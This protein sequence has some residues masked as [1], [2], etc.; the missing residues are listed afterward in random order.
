MLVRRGGGGEERRGE[1]RRGEGRRG[2]KGRGEERR[3]KEG[4]GE[5]RKKAYIH[6]PNSFLNFQPPPPGISKTIKILRGKC[7]M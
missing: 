2:E 1:E 5:Q 6:E 3:G 7:F 4:R